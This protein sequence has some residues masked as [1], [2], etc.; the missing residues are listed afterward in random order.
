MHVLDKIHEIKI[1]PVI[2]LDT[3]NKAKPL[4]EAL[5][6]GNLPAAEITFRSDAAEASISVIVKEYPHM[7]VGAGTLVSVDQAQRALDAGA[8][9]FVTAG[10]HRGVTEFAIDKN[11]PIFPG[12]C[13]PTELMML[14]EYDLAVAKFFPANQ[15]GGLATIKSFAGPFPSI[16]FM[17]TGG[18]N[19]NNVV[20]YLSFDKVIACGG[21]W[22]VKDDLIKDGDFD[23][24]RRLTCET[25]DLISG[26]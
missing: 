19:I 1:V 13:T 9:F 22:M 5:C 21:S 26:V 2:K 24:I 23:E 18:I 3:S 25:M 4:A 16:R 7:L 10:F 12:I 17:P 8:A 11:I 15:F 20:E 6:M 14:L